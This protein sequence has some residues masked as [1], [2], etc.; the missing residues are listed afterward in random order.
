MMDASFVPELGAYI[1][2]WIAPD[3]SRLMVQ[4]PASLELALVRLVELLEAHGDTERPSP[5]PAA[6]LRGNSPIGG[7]R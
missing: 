2:H 4:H 6:A 1:V 3:A 5:T 7:L